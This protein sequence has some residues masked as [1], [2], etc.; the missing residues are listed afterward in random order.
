MGQNSRIGR[1]FGSTFP[2][3]ACVALLA[4]LT[5]ACCCSTFGTVI[6]D[7]AMAGDLAKVQALL[8][9]NPALVC[10][11]DPKGLTPLHLAAAYGHEDVAALLLDSQACV[12]AKAI[13]GSTPLHAAAAHGRSE[14]AKLLLA[15]KAD[16]NAKT[17]S[18]LT[19]LHLAALLD[20]AEIAILLLENHADV[21]AKSGAGVADDNGPGI[22]VVSTVLGAGFTVA[23]GDSFG[24]GAT[25]LHL[26]A[27]SGYKNLAEIL[28]AHGADINARNNSGKTP[29]QLAKSRKDMAD[30]L[31]RHGARE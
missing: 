18:G 6:N 1:H 7:A 29:L 5:M 28:L 16:V 10:S 14:V 12:D 25:P 4:L 11:K 8:K 26:A 20:H 31:R 17:N 19:P 27:M 23:H 30:S 15:A 13:D 3:P 24:G 9:D 21:N 2:R 22:H